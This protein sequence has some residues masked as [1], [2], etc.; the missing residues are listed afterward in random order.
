[1]AAT[2]K[3][4]VALIIESHG[5]TRGL[6][7]TMDPPCCLAGMHCLAIWVIGFKNTVGRGVYKGA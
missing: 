7:D 2:V 3:N 4:A 1:M 6:P 5:L